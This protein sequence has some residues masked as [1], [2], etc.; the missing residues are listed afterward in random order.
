[1]IEKLTSQSKRYVKCVSKDG[2]S[3]KEIQFGLKVS[4]PVVSAKGITKMK[5]MTMG[6]GDVGKSSL[7]A[8]FMGNAL[9]FGMN[10]LLD[11]EVKTDDN[12]KVS[13]GL[14]LKFMPSTQKEKEKLNK[15]LLE[16]KA[17]DFKLGKKQ[18]KLNIGSFKTTFNVAG[19]GEGYLDNGKVMVN[20]VVRACGSVS[21]SHTTNFFWIVPTYISVSG[22]GKIEA[23]IRGSIINQNG[24]NLNGLLPKWTSGTIAPSISVAIE[25]GVGSKGIANFGAEGRGTVKY[26]ADFVKST[27]LCEL[28]ASA[29]SQSCSVEV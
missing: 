2:K 7:A 24:L 11:L 5:F 21:G 28:T 13:V 6:E 12:G 8:L 23:E 3:S 26:T 17:K 22:E 1:M 29:S 25:G 20:I 27:Q 16:S 10:D 19:Y 4:K 14:N 15:E 9:K 18:P